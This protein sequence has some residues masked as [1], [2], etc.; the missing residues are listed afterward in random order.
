MTL[1]WRREEKITMALKH[2]DP[3][4]PSNPAPIFG[5]VDAARGDQMRANNNFIW[6][7]EQD[8]DT[9]VTSLETTD[10][11]RVSGPASSVNDD[12]AF[13]SGTTG[14]VLQDKSKKIATDFTVLSN[15]LIPTVQSVNAYTGTAFGLYV[16][17]HNF[18]PVSQCALSGGVDGS[19]Y[20]NFLNALS[21]TSVQI[22]ASL[23]VPVLIALAD[24]EDVVGSRNTVI[25]ITANTTILTGLSTN[26]TY[27]IYV[28]VD[29][30][31]GAVTFGKTTYAPGYVTINGFTPGGVGQH[32]YV[33]PDQKMY[34]DT[35][36]VW[37][38][39]KRVFIG[40]VTVAGGV[41]SSLITYAYKGRYISPL[42]ALP[43]AAISVL[44][45]N[46]GT[47]LLFE[48][49]DVI[50]ITPENGFVAGDII[51]LI[52][53]VTASGGNSSPQTFHNGLTHTFIGPVSGNNYAY[54][55][56]G[57]GGGTPGTNMSNSLN[58]NYRVILK[59]AF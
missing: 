56:T 7:N 27:Y 20:A 1:A 3:S 24:G 4:L 2:T 5:D 53:K 39:V 22:L 34:S 25:A 14:K 9:R 36:S 33:I 15:D 13:F 8:L 58:W 11:S 10:P 57:A 21:T 28:D 38:A 30:S 46:I 49:V 47:S 48:T 18:V 23:S 44:N 31:T 51:K 40:Q 42:T 6:D 37:T 35:G 43:N 12:I 16:F 59:R 41:I 50:N 55:S 45:H 32:Y 29:R 54:T 17:N 19:G 26:G 52:M